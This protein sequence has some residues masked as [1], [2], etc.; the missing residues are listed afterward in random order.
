[1]PRFLFPAILILAWEFDRRLGRRQTRNWHTERTARYRIKS[2]AMKEFDRCRIATMFTAYAQMNLVTL[3]RAGLGHGIFDQN[4]NTFLVHGRKWV[5]NID[6][7]R[8][9]FIQNLARVGTRHT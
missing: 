3:G 9:I 4:A 2:N 7:T 1:M 6:S 5:G 8:T